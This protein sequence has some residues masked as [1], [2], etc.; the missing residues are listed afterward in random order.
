[1]ISMDLEKIYIPREQN[2]NTGLD[3]ETTWTHESGWALYT[4]FKNKSGRDLTVKSITLVLGTGN[5]YFK[6]SNQSANGNG[7]QIYTAVKLNGVV[8]NYLYVKNVV[9]SI[10]NSNG[11]IYYPSDNNLQYHTFTFS[12]SV[13]LKNGQTYEIRLDYLKPGKT[14]LVMKTY[15]QRGYPSTGSYMSVEPAQGT[16]YTVKFYSGYA[17]GSTE[18]P[19]ELLK[20]DSVSAG[21]SSQPPEV[22]RDGY[23]FAG[24][25]GNYKNVTKDEDVYATW[26][27]AQSPAPSPIWIRQ[28]GKWVRKTNINR[29]S[30]STKTWS[31]IE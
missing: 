29:Y 30:K 28:N 16:A 7:G 19:G 11:T 6:N 3:A 12:N 21:G 9:N 1:M 20:T 14:V 26:E 15:Y 2:P 13:T 18:L 24:W 22:T 23:T 31:K 5:G 8:S 4:K 10:S 27:A 17:S 25:L